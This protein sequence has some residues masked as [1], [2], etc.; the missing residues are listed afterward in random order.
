MTDIV[1]LETHVLRDD[2]KDLGHLKRVYSLINFVKPMEI[3][4][5]N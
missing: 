3:I 5:E 1:V 4:Q 2:G